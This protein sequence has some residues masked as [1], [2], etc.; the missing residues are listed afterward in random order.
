MKA[1]EL[2]TGLLVWASL[3]VFCAGIWLAL[4]LLFLLGGLTAAMAAV[5]WTQLRGP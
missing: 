3:L 1:A 4:P 2:T 5:I